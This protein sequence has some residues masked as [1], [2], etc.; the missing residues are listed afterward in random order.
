MIDTIKDDDVESL[1]ENHLSSMMSGIGGTQIGQ[2]GDTKKVSIVDN[3]QANFFESDKAEFK[4]IQ[5]T[6]NEETR[7]TISEDKVGKTKIA[8]AEK[9]AGFFGRRGLFGTR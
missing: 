1:G 4:G 8:N 6:S 7:P 5:D 9:P 3:L 2:L